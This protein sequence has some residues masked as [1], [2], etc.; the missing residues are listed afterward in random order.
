MTHPIVETAERAFMGYDRGDIYD[1]AGEP[2][3]VDERT[4]DAILAALREMR[5]PAT[6]GRLTPWRLIPS[7]ECPAAMALI[8]GYIDAVIREIEQ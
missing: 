3:A 8:Q 2:I 1:Q 5:K 7:M 4:R 6:I